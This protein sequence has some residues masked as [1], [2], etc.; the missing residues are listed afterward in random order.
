M[1]KWPYNTPR[2]QRLRRYVLAN[3]PLCRECRRAGRVTQATDVDHIEPVSQGGAAFDLVNLQPLCRECHNRKINLHEGGCW[4]PKRDR[5]VDAKTG[6]PMDPAHWWNRGDES[7]Q[8]VAQDRR[9]HR[10]SHKTLN[11]RRFTL[12]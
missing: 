2:W 7:C 1:A 12:A 11:R 4:N 5:R 3:E 9:P 8:P 10:S 6:Q